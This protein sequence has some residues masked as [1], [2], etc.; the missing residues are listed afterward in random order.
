M[1]NRCGYDSMPARTLP[2]SSTALPVFLAPF[3]LLPC[4]L[5]FARLPEK[6]DPTPRLLLLHFFL[7]AL[8]VAFTQTA[9]ASR[10]PRPSVTTHHVA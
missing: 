9:C 5:P 6:T 7:T 1:T 8:A 3:Y 4:A 2:L 10:V